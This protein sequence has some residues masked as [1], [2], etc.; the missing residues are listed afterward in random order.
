MKKIV[1][2][3]FC[4]TLCMFLL[5][6]CKGEKE[7]IVEGT[8]IYYLNTEGTGLIK[9]KYSIKG[10]TVEDKVKFLLQEMQKK[11]DCIDY[12]SPFPE[13][14]KIE[15]YKIE[16]TLLD[17]H[18]NVNYNKMDAVTEVL[19]RAAIVQTL[20]QI[21]EIEYVSFYAAGHPIT[22]DQ[23]KEIGYQNA[24]DFVQNIG[25]T[26]HSYQ[27]GELI[28]YFASKD[29]QKL[30]SENVN[31]RYNS[32]ISMEKLIVEEVIEGPMSAE[33]QATFAD[34]TKVLGV[35]V[36]DGVCYVNF[37]ENFLVNQVAIDP[38]VT[39][40]SLVNSIVENGAATKVQILVNG[41]TN[42]KYQE[43]VDLNEQFSRNLEI[44]EEEK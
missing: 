9:E 20:T 13:D 24:A 23:G 18:F 35:S 26:L 36:K 42:V 27:K 16:R 39:V 15:E 8:G 1:N 17:I 37:D 30:K 28:L 12:I 40:Y 38:N 29:G 41:E 14:V 5:V 22:D 43:I 11:T 33:L 4:L 10:E 2:T 19:L 32:N 21:P 31:V 6:G 44:V 34:N 25:S 3:I 7:Q